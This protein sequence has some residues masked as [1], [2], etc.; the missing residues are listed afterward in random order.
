MG[1]GTSI[2]VLAAAAAVIV[3]VGT[4]LSRLADRLADRLGIGEALVG[5]VLL[6]ASTSL[7][8]IVVSVSAALHDRP[9]L[10]F[11]NAVGGIAVQTVFIVLADAFHR[12]ANLEHAVASLENVTYAVLLLFLLSLAL[13]AALAPPVAVLGVHPVSPAI[14]VAYVYG[15]RA[16]RQSRTHPMWQPTPTAETEPDVPDAAAS[17]GP[18]S[19]ALLA[20]FAPLAAAIALAGWVVERSAT[21][22]AQ[23]TGISQ[24]VVGALL[25]SVVTSLPELVTAVAA[26]RIGAL[27]LA[28]GG[29]L[30]GNAF[31]TL[32]LVGADVA[33]RGGSLYHAVARVDLYLLALCLTL[34]CVAVIGLVRRERHGIA[35]VG[36]E[37]LLLVVLYVGGMVLLVAGG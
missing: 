5:A 26:V 22:L 21:D 8:G 37:G 36:L 3:L 28:V 33:F 29:L 11:S 4:R 18:S 25:T 19:A 15:L 31:D 16:V 23:Q 10:A 9:N 17:R 6:G 12:R 24:S 7:P 32:F 35:N 1:L 34:T 14:L 30:G 20:R 2:A 13:L 27:S